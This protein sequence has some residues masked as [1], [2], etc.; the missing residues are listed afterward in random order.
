MTPRDL[1]VAS[2]VFALIYSVPSSCTCILNAQR[3]ANG[4]VLF[5]SVCEYLNLSEAYYFGLMWFHP[6]MKKWVY[7]EY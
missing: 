6:D 4:S 1:I 5:D 3:S 7:F 2:F